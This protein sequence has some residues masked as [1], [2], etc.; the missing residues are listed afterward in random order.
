MMLENLKDFM[1]KLMEDHPDKD[2]HWDAWARRFIMGIDKTSSAAQRAIS[3]N[4]LR[5]GQV[6]GLPN[7]GSLEFEPITEDNA[8]FMKYVVRNHVS[9]AVI[10]WCESTTLTGKM[11]DEAEAE[12][13]RHMITAENLLD[14]C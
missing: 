8:K 5:F 10:K 14:F 3:M 7:I 13:E 12:L 4:D 2:S 6:S 1:N 9:K 11:K